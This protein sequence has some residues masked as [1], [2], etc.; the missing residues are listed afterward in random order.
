MYHIKPTEIKLILLI[1]Y[2]SII[3]LYIVAVT[4]KA[5][6]DANIAKAFEYFQCEATG[7]ETQCSISVLQTD[8]IT[9]EIAVG[10]LNV[11]L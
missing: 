8:I 11:L 10:L 7:V 1:L 5:F 4:S 9:H 2:Y 3:C 6:S